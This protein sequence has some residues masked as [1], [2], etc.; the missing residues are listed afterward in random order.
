MSQCTGG[1]AGAYHGGDHS[2]G[3]NKLK[4]DGPDRDPPSGGLDRETQAQ[5]SSLYGAITGHVAIGR[6]LLEIGDPSGAVI[7]EASGAD[8]KHTRPRPAP[9]LLL[10]TLIRGLVGREAELATIISALDAGLPLEV[11]GEPGTGKTALLRHLAHHPRTGSFAD[12]VVYL[13]ARRLAFGDLLQLIFEAFHESGGICKPTDAEI[14][15]GLLDK[16]ALILVDDVR[17][18][19]DELEQVFGIAPRSAFVVATRARCLWNEGRT[20]A[21]NGLPAEAGVLL[22]E[23]AI[24]RPLDA[25]ERS[26]A[27]RFCAALGGQPLRI[28][29]AAALVRETGIA[30]D[31]SIAVM[32][33]EDVLT[34]LV[35]ST[36]DKQRRVLLALTALPGVPLEL[37]HISN[38]AEVTDVEPSMLALV[39]RGLVIRSRS[40]HQLASGVADR[41]RRTDDL[42]PWV[43]RAITYFTE[44]AARYRRSPNLLFEQSEAL[45][46]AQECAADARRWGEVLRLGQLV[47][48][49]L[50]TGGRWGAWAL[51]LDR[52]LAAAKASGD[53]AAEAW[54]LHQRG[55]R[56]VCLDEPGFAR[57]ALGQAVKL[58]EALPDEP[59]AK[60]SQRNLGFV[61]APV[62]ALADTRDRSTKWFGVDPGALPLRDAVPSLG[63]VPRANGYAALWLAAAALLFLGSFGYLAFD[64]E[65]TGRSWLAALRSS[66]HHASPGQA[67]VVIPPQPAVAAPRIDT[68]VEL[69]SIAADPSATPVP[70]PTSGSDSS[71]ILIF[72]VRPAGAATRWAQICYAVSGA[73]QARIEPGIGAVDPTSTLSCRRVAPGRTTTYQL[74]AYGRD[75]RQASEQVVVLVR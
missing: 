63:R 11:S 69:D 22:L 67:A 62:S 73:Y 8:R 40:R 61:L 19:E 72:T 52:C 50:I 65:R 46:R 27:A 2:S 71:R 54:V 31:G 42:N 5:E 23:R 48:G 21:L 3:E 13:S 55:S 58:R 45:L 25:A 36:D 28:L 37:T 66:E 24:E 47:E 60:A 14:R 38:I 18:A 20:L 51:A 29:Q 39:H 41:L 44:W 32:R 33:P 70:Q 68:S 12:G 57:D 43:N 35:K 9:V 17:L 30:L 10:P 7:R 1:W 34:D 49:A 53:R 6:Y 16:Q 64:A 26:D 4:L 74:T 56:A 15:R 75:G 59:A